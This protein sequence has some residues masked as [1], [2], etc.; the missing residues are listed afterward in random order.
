MRLPSNRNGLIHPSCSQRITAPQPSPSLWDCRNFPF[1]S[2]T[3]F[4]RNKIRA[5]EE[6][7]PKVDPLH[8][9]P[10][11]T[12]TFSVRSVVVSLFSRVHWPSCLPAP[13]SVHSS[14]K[15]STL[16]HFPPLTTH[17]H[18]CNFP[19]LPPN[20]KLTFIHAAP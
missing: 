20:P 17:S 8:P 18:Q 9:T 13:A 7:A 1:C 14:P 11:Y 10:F 6:S 15:T 3:T 2:L 4:S 5:A 16:C 19:T 12:F